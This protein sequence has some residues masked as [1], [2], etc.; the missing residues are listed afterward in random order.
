VDA[1][2]DLVGADP[3]QRIPLTT[4]EELAAWAASEPRARTLAFDV[5][6]VE[7]ELHRLDALLDG[8]LAMCRRHAALRG[9]RLVLLS[10]QAEVHAS[11]RARLPT[12][13]ELSCFK[14]VPDFELGGAVPIARQLG[15]RDVSIGVT[16]L[17]LWSEVRRDVA[18]AVRERRR[19][20]LDSIT[21]WGVDDDDT[22]AELVHFGVDGIITSKIQTTRELIAARSRK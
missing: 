19:G 13:E 15:A 18:D 5:K 14:L 2:L 8:M 7:R 20:G 9:R 11:L 1:A 22:L 10:T 16:P 12:I 17:R 3:E 6:L 21:V 4:L